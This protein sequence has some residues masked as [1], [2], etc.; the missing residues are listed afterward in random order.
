LYLKEINSIPKESLQYKLSSKGFFDKITVPD[1]PIG[2]SQVYLRISHRRWL[3]EDTR[4]IL[5]R[6]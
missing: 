4:K 3:Y 1:F 5:F 6:D 2:G